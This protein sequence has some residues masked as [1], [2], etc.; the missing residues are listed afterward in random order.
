MF[1]ELYQTV[2]MRY[3]AGASSQSMSD[4]I[5][6]NTTYKLRPFSLEGYEFQRAIA[7]DMH[8]DLSVKKCSQVGLTEI[9]LRKFLAM[10]T[11][12][13]AASGIFTL[14]T[15]KMF[16]NVS[17]TRLRPLLD[18]DG[19]H[20]PE[21]RPTLPARGLPPVRGVGG[22]RAQEAGRRRARA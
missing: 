12:N 10:L 3:G 18:Q 2:K 20:Y 21:R 22:W 11:R 19:R 14:P 15:E 7:D 16:S 13:K 17:K 5:T 1:E 8:P 9:Q 4:W 6:R